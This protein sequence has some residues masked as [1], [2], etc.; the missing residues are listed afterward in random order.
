MTKELLQLRKPRF[1]FREGAVF[2]H[3]VHLLKRLMNL[4]FFQRSLNTPSFVKAKLTYPI[5]L[6]P[7]FSRKVL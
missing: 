6:L 7:D 3:T 4:S 1:S 5:E 2:S